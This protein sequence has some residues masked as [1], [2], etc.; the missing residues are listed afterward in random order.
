M[1]IYNSNIMKNIILNLGV[2][3][4]FTALLIPTFSSCSKSNDEANQPSAIASDDFTSENTSIKDTPLISDEEALL[5][6]R[7][8]EKMARDV[9]TLLNNKWDLQVFENITS[10]EQRHMDRM[11]DLLNTYGLDDPALSGYG[12][13]TNED[14]QVRYDK[15]IGL[16]VESLENALIVGANIEEIDIMDLQNFIDATEDEYI[17]CVLGNLMRAS[18]NHLRAFF[19]HLEMRDIDYTPQYLSPEEF[20]AIVHGHHEAGGT[21]C[22]Q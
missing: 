13:F 4:A 2:S 9:Y 8:E 11:L 5:F 3:I 16:G 21:P 19:R 15:L 22:I 12:I 6:M 18:R 14:I 1:F 10:S 7:E 20:D 17:A